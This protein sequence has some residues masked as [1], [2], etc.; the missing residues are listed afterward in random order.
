MLA[1]VVWDVHLEDSWLLSVKLLRLLPLPR[2]ITQIGL[3]SLEPR[4]GLTW[5]VALPFRAQDEE[6]GHPELRCWVPSHTIIGT[7]TE[8]QVSIGIQWNTSHRLVTWNGL[9]L[10]LTSKGISACSWVLEIYLYGQRKNFY[11]L[12]VVTFPQKPIEK[13]HKF[14][15]L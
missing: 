10:S 2:P 5:L 15:V 13:H 7:D 6:R 14:L 3:G 8:I 1:Q 11:G 9:N 4:A 12:Q